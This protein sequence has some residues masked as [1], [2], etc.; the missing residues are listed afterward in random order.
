MVRDTNDL[1]VCLV[2]R[3]LIDNGYLDLEMLGY[4]SAIQLSRDH[5]LFRSLNVSVELVRKCTDRYPSKMLQRYFA[6]PPC[7]GRRLGIASHEH[8][9]NQQDSHTAGDS[10]VTL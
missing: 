2:C 9:N 10:N 6:I 1:P 4:N 5:N 7:S 3:G 8:C